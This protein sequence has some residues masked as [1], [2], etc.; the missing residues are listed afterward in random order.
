M[1]TIGVTALGSRGTFEPRIVEI[2]MGQL[3]EVVARSI[4]AKL[5]PENPGL[6]AAEVAHKSFSEISDILVSR[7]ERLKGEL[8]A[9]EASK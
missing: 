4:Y 5:E 3:I 1:E 8:A 9:F 2:A 6:R 7:L